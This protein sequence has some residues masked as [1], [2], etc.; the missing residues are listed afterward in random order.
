MIDQG[1]PFTTSPY[2]SPGLHSCNK[3]LY[4]L[5]GHSGPASL[6]FEARCRDTGLE[7]VP[8]SVE[9]FDDLDHGRFEEYQKQFETHLSDAHVA[10]LVTDPPCDTFLNGR[11]RDS[12]G[13]GRY[14]LPRRRLSRKSGKD[15]Y[16]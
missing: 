2:A 16:D 13:P 10:G 9:N 5:F 4:H 15:T 8:L 3:K 14:G 7:Y 11:L 1:A 6:D 12:V